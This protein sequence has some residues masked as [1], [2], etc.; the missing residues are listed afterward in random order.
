MNRV[1]LQAGYERNSEHPALRKAIR[2]AGVMTAMTVLAGLVATGSALGQNAYIPNGF[3]HTV[4]VIDTKTNTV[5]KT[6]VLPEPNRFPG[7]VAVSPS[8]SRA[9]IT[10]LCDGGIQGL[11][12]CMPGDTG[13]VSVIDTATNTVIATIVVGSEPSGIA[14]TPDD[15]RVYVVN[16][17]DSNC[18]AGDPATTASSISVID[19]LS[20]SPTE[21]TVIRTIPL[22]F[23]TG[24]AGIGMNQAGS[25]VFV[26]SISDR[27]GTG[28]TLAAIETATGTILDVMQIPV[29]ATQLVMNPASARLYIA[30]LTGELAVID[31]ASFSYINNVTVSPG[32]SLVIKPDGTRL[33]VTNINGGDL[34]VLDS[35][36]DDLSLVASVSA[37]IGQLGIAAHPDGSKVYVVDA[38]SDPGKVWILNTATNTY[39]G[40]QIVVGK[41]PVGFGQFIGSANA[42]S[43]PALV[44]LV[45]SFNLKEGIANSLDAKL[46]NAQAALTAANAGQRQ[47]AVNLLQA[48]LNTVEA[49]RNKAITNAQADQ[50]VNLCRQIIASLQL[51][52][53]SAPS[54]RP[55]VQQNPLPGAGNIKGL[56][57]VVKNLD[58]KLRIDPATD[59]KIQALQ[60]ALTA[61][62]AGQRTTAIAQLQ[63]FIAAATVQRG[64]TLTNAQAD[65]LIRS[66]N[67]I[68][69]KL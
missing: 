46:A 56:M 25:L 58:R 4:S 44:A 65:L 61:A 30:S 50:L 69:G 12:T 63:A 41:F 45:K 67:Q 26:S 17:C 10:N 7:G 39:S 9:Y 43:I 22:P 33:Y 19:A 34:M 3:D 64:A 6:I 36:N 42:S 53:S 16:G 51:N 23:A 55:V 62:T 1:A 2:T 31:T 27:T 29:V 60:A 11:S 21:N 18:A 66:A 5:V 54:S 49:Q 52:S 8:G 14:V 15:S 24:A 57:Q 32:I 20:G 47:N 38:L 37:E 28:G 68:I 48:F 13:S 40:T 59:A 35:S